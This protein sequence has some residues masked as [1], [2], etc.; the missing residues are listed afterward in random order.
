VLLALG[1][2]QTGPMMDLE[3]ALSTTRAVR[4]RMAMIMGDYDPWQS[5][6]DSVKR[7]DRI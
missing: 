2:R 6:C 1:G 3:H 7:S 4:K 5:P